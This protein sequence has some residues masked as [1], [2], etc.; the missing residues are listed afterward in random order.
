MS[1]KLISLNSITKFW[2]NTKTYIQNYV[3]SFVNNKLSNFIQK[4]DIINS[5]TSTDAT[6]VA[7]APT[8]KTLND[9]LNQLNMNLSNKQDNLGYTP[10]QQG[11]G[12][13][14]G[15]NKVYIGWADGRLKTQVDALD[16]GNMVFDSNMNNALANYVPK[17]SGYKILSVQTVVVTV[18]SA[19]AYSQ[20]TGTS[21]FNPV[22]GATQYLLMFKFFGWWN[23][24]GAEIIGNAVNASFINCSGQTHSGSAVFDVIAIAPL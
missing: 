19:P 10:V 9:N 7:A 15:A 22:A 3:S 24:S 11:G 4:N 8:V 21:Y 17:N 12:A 20:A 23:V 14:Q 16:L 13:G 1:N 2:S 6:K 18:P 5:F